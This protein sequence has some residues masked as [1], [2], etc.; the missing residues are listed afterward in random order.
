MQQRTT[1]KDIYPGYHDFAP[2]GVVLAA[3]ESNLKVKSTQSAEREL[4]EEMGIQGVPLEPLFDFYYESERTKLWGAAFFARWNGPVRLQPEEVQSVRL[5]TLS[6]I[7]A[8]VQTGVKYCPDSLA[9]LEQ[10]ISLG[11]V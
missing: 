7:Q 10:F 9:A 4:T 6:E 8:E 2:G 1:T 11:K 5:L 3:D